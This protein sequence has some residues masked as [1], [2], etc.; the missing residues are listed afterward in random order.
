MSDIKRIYM[1]YNATAPISKPVRDFF[2]QELDFFANGSSL[3][4]D[5][6]TVGKHLEKA[7]SQVAALI[8]AEPSEIIFTS[9][10]SESNNTVF[11]SMIS[12]S[13]KNGRKLIVTSSI[14][15]PC[16]IESSKR[17]ADFGF[18]VQRLPVDAYGVVDMAAYKKLLEKK[19]LIVSIMTANNEIGT[20]Q[21]IKTLA[22]MAHEAGALFHTD[23]VQAAG[24]IPVD[25]KDWNVDYLTISGHKIYAP[26]GV[27]ALFVKKGA[28]V[29]PFILGGHQEH[30]LRAG[31]YNAPVIAA[32]G[33]AAE[34]AKQNLAEYEK[35]TRALRNKLRD[36]LLAKIPDIKI[37][38]HPEKVLPNTIDI[39]FPGAEGEAILLHLDLLGVSVSTGSACAS[40]SLEPSHVLLATGLGPELAHGSI[41]FSFGLYSEESD[42]DYILEK[43]PPVI[44]N[45]RKMSTVYSAKK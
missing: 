30:G 32:F 8:N 27:G 6:R 23:A 12:Y 26:K 43:F 7:R 11:N 5:G 42:V 19:P 13:E 18:D 37:N 17:L 20:I 29:S 16:V 35:H 38:G 45:L 15:H 3:H 1:D 33:Y 34:L 41:R 4:E 28:P 24:K 44:E 21:D 36:G 39:S 31:T 9:G 22:A 10:G 40:G 25:V 14:E 2:V